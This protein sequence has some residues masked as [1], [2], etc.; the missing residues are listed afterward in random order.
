MNDNVAQMAHATPVPSAGVLCFNSVGH[1]LLVNPTYKPGWNL[2]GGRV[3]QGEA[4]RQAAVREVREEL[5]L[6]L[7]LSIGLEPLVVAWVAG[8]SAR[9]LFLFDAGELT[10]G[11]QASIR[12][13][14]SELGAYAFYPI[15]DID[16]TIAPPGLLQVLRLALAARASGRPSYIEVSA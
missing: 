3:D 1:L 4:P 2:P 5:G 11:Q 8:P 6:D 12:L 10:A 14:A 13:Q 15:A 7:D 9:V 16:T